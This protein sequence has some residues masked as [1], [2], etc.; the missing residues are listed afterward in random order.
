MSGV[1]IA[2]RE[3][4]LVVFTTLAPSGAVAFLLMSLPLL[5]G[6]G[7]VTRREGDA[8]RQSR[9][10]EKALYVPILL[11]LVGLVASASH[12]GTPSNA[13]YVLSRI[14]TS[15]LSNEVLAVIVFLGFACVYW[16]YSFALRP[17]RSLQVALL[18]LADV[19]TVVFVVSVGLAYSVKTIVTWSNAFVPASLALTAV[20]GGP[21]VALATMQACGC[22]ACAGTY[23]RALLTLS[24]VALVGSVVVMAAQGLNPPAYR[25]YLTDVRTLVPHYW[26]ML[27][28]YALLCSGGI[29]AA[30]LSTHGTKAEGDVG[31]TKDEGATL[32]PVRG[33]VVC[34]VGAALALGGI[35]IMRFAFYMSH[36]TAGLGA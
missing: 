34:A 25:N 26:L 14:G 4:S 19:M 18:L 8:G 12:L 5:A 30:L 1:A 21:L 2:M 3:L 7:R 11:T 29:I 13:L 6:R 20:V 24:F 23:R 22:W 17:A 28:A 31:G 16:L 9:R 32:A 10:L 15:P 35:F 33:R 27:A 36:M